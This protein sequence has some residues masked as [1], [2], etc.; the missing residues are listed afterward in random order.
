MKLTGSMNI[1]CFSDKVAC[2]IKIDAK[3]TFLRNN[4]FL[5]CLCDKWTAVKE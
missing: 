5:K 2:A 1:C 4:S 3:E